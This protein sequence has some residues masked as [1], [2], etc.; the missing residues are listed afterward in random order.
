MF[1]LI[2]IQPI[3]KLGT[4]NSLLKGPI[5]FINKDHSIL[6]KEITVFEIRE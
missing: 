2:P 3:S 4:K 5:V 6:K 1:S